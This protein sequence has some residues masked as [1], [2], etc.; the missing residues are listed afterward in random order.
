M[1]REYRRK[2]VFKADHVKFLIDTYVRQFIAFADY[3][4]TFF[5]EVK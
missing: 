3:W 2:K 1:R 4:G 5:V